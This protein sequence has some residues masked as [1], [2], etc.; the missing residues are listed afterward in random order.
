[1]HFLMTFYFY[2]TTLFHLKVTARLNSYRAS[3]FRKNRSSILK[4]II[5]LFYKQIAENKIY[6]ILK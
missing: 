4:Y 2:L 1:M 6:E 5:S 3:H